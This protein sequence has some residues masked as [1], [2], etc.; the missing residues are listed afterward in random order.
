VDLQAF[1]P[2]DEEKVRKLRPP[3]AIQPA[4]SSFLNDSLYFEIAK[5][6]NSGNSSKDLTPIRMSI[7]CS[8]ADGLR[9]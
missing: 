6:K 3:C 7:F 8:S 9:R 1:L 5:E 4:K 2:K